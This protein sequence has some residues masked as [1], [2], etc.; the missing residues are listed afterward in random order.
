MKNPYWY[1][2]PLTTD[3]FIIYK[4]NCSK[5]GKI[6]NDELRK[7][8]ISIYSTANFFLDCL[9]TNNNC[10]EYYEKIVD[11]YGNNTGDENI[12]CALERLVYSKVKNILP[13]AEKLK[14]LLDNLE[15]L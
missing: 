4:A 11:K 14:C 6:K 8:I 15:E 5:I 13:A 9:R 3:Y 10:I 12:K 7:T 1:S 2:Y